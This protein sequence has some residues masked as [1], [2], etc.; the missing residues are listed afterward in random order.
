M[1]TIKIN[2]SILILLFF[3]NT[4]LAQTE[5]VS[6]KGSPGAPHASAM[7]DVESS[8]KGILIPRVALTALNNIAPM[9]TT[10]ATALL[11]YNTTLNPAASL[12]PGFY[13]WEGIWKKLNSGAELWKVD[14]NNANSIYYSQPA[15]GTVQVGARTT[16]TS[17]YTTTFQVYGP[18]VFFSMGAGASSPPGPRQGIIIGDAN[19]AAGVVPQGSPGGHWNEINCVSEPLDL[20]WN[21]GKDVQ[22]GAW[23]GS[24]LF[25]FRGA[26]NK[27]NIYA[28]GT[29]FAQSQA[30]TSDST[31]KKDITLFQNVSQLVSQCNTY[32][33]NYKTESSAEKK[34]IGVIAQELEHFFPQLIR[35]YSQSKV[36]SGKFTEAE[37]TETTSFKTVD[38][39]GLTAV[40]LQAIKELNARI[41]VL[42]NR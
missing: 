8:T 26:L 7:L 30:L 9:A 1:K 21:T 24:N 28:E 5:G 36:T 32:S 12:S 6:I 33:Y 4:I 20:Q 25:V 13:Y 39:A 18:S 14:A 35:E 38:Y 27:G 29:V 31:L 41:E 15:N 10:P 34:H 22:M 11:V 3:G 37:T 16:P 17:A 40:L 2:F 19:N 23:A 42:E